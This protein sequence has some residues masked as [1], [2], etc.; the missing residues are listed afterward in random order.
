MAHSTD[1]RPLTSAAFLKC[2]ATTRFVEVA[3]RF[4]KRNGRP[5]LKN[6]TCACGRLPP[7]WTCSPV[8]N[9]EAAAPEDVIMA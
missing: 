7:L 8:A 1:G 4:G 5:G 2:C 6:A 3:S 9:S